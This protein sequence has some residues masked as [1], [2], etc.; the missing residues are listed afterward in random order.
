MN[1]TD[2]VVRGSF[3]E[4]VFF[5]FFS[6]SFVLKFNPR[7]G[8]EGDVQRG[9]F[10]LDGPVTSRARSAVVCVCLARGGTHVRP[11]CG[12][13]SLPSPSPPVSRS[14]FFS[15]FLLLF[16]SLHLSPFWS[17]LFHPFS[18]VSPFLACRMSLED[19]PPRDR[20]AKPPPVSRCFVVPSLP[21]RVPP[22]PSKQD[23]EQP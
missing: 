17:L 19:P 22:S 11:R 18:S 9:G 3:T 8:Q 12:F 5:L 23:W 13:A 20:I 16:L 14:L 15:L 7:M 21:E 2:R 10:R 1:G 6:L 4:L